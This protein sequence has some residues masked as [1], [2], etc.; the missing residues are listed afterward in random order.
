M[1]QVLYIVTLKE[2]NMSI[3]KFVREAILANAEA[4]TQ[5]ILDQ[6]QAQFPEAKTSPACIAWYKSDMRKKG[7][8]G[9]GRIGN[10]EAQCAKLQDEIDFLTNAEKVAARVADL[11]AKIAKLQPAKLQPAVAEEQQA[12]KAAEPA[13]AEE[14][15]AT[16]K[17]RR[18]KAEA[19]EAETEA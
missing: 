2:H 12:A 10:R 5:E 6:V 1:G 4:T 11:Q 17:A 18:A 8:L 3:G 7:L 19:V 14:K 13:V 15:A 16:K 9:G